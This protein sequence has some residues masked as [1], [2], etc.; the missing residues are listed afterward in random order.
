MPQLMGEAERRRQGWVCERR[1][2]ALRGT[3]DRQIDTSRQLDGQ[4][5]DRLDR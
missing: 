4:P 5:G 1:W 3:G 2:M